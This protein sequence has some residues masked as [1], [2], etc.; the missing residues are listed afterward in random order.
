M[1]KKISVFGSTGSIGTSTLK[2]VRKY[3]QN[4][5][6]NFLSAYSNIDL[7]KKQIIEFKPEFISIPKKYSDNI[8]NDFKN[9][10]ILEGKSGLLKATEI[11][12]IDLIVMGISGIAGLAPTLY[13]L[14]NKKI[15]ALANKES[16]VSGGQF[17]KPYL[18]S[19]IPIDSEHSSLFQLLKNVKKEEV[20]NI[21][22]TASGGPFLN[23]KLD[24]NIKKE[25]VLDHPNWIMGNKV[26]V[27]SA[28]MANKALEIIEAF[29]LF[30]FQP[31]QIKIIVQPQSIIHSLIEFTDGSFFSQMNF[32]DMMFSISYA[33]FYPERAPRPLIGNKILENSSLDFIAP[34]KIKF[35]FIDIAYDCINK[36]GNRPIVFNSANEA[37]VSLFIDNKIKFIDIF[38]IVK[39]IYN[40]IPFKQIKNFD[41]IFNIDKKIK[42]EIKGEYR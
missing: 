34:D 16:I 40:K 25:D 36:G 15:V 1:M 8:K 12:D 41:E 21:Y 3:P 33:L 13:S 7:L 2:I 19:I 23:S 35:P 20:K 39:K 17:I 42:D 32:P 31:S 30:S 26:T 37:A 28:T 18:N 4:F 11:D 24:E 10:K 6:V 22:I 14:K 9:I 5:K 29:Y 27:D 38:K